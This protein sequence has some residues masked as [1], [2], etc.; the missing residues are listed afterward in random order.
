MIRGGPKVGFGF[1]PKAEAEGLKNFGFWPKAEAEAEG[2]DFKI[3][4]IFTSFQQKEKIWK[5]EKLD[6]IS[7]KNI[8]FHVMA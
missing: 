5:L 1:W 6:W 2:L 7:D 4:M 8:H 3:L